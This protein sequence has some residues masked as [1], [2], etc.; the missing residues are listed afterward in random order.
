MF[1]SCSKLKSVDLSK[2]NTSNVRNMGFMF[3][4]CSNLEKIEFGNINTPSL[5]NIINDRI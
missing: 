3:S 1:A 4:G 2:F 5:E